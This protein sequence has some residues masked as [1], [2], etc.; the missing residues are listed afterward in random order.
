MVSTSQLV[1]GNL[2]SGEIRFKVAI[3][4][5]PDISFLPD[6]LRRIEAAGS[7]ESLLRSGNG[8]NQVGGTTTS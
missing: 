4:L 2:E 6:Q 3:I 5:T 1:T 7:P 8:L